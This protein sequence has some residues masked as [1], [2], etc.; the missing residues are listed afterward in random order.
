MV[1]ALS[2][3]SAVHFPAG[4]MHEAVGPA[5]TAVTGSLVLAGAHAGLAQVVLYNPAHPLPLLIVAVDAFSISAT[6]ITLFFT[7]SCLLAP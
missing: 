3:R 7:P 1:T 2:G 6:V 4:I 5:R